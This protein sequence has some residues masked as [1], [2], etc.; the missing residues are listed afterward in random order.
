[1]DLYHR[2]P[3]VAASMPLARV[4]SRRVPSVYESIKVRSLEEFKVHIS[5]IRFFQLGW[6]PK[7]LGALQPYLDW[8]S[9]Y[10]SSCRVCPKRCCNKFPLP[11]GKTSR[12]ADLMT[13][14]HYRGQPC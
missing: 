7:S 1:M 11:A 2:C 4:L 9:H 14:C 8:F 6:T 12:L 3:T 13:C 10:T 5:A